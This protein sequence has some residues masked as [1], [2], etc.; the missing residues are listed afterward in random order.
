MHAAFLHDIVVPSSVVG[1]STRVSLTDGNT[2]RV[3][4][5]P[6]DKEAVE[7]KV[8]AMA[9]AYQRLTTHKIAIEFKKPTSHQIKKLEAKK[10]K[11]Q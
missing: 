7:D 1:R 5:D 2:E 10:A 3:F 4:L 11:G 6:M 8:E 9:H